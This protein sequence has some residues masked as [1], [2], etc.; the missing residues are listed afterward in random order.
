MEAASPWVAEDTGGAG[1]LPD[2]LT[3]L[4]G[5]QL[6]ALLND[7]SENGT[8]CGVCRRA[9]ADCCRPPPPWNG[10]T[11]CFGSNMVNRYDTHDLSR[12]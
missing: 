11:V 12:H 4:E 6:E 8:L 3:R 7:G 10:I 1:R 2:R 9:L 5:F